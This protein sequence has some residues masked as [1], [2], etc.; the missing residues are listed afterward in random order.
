VIAFGL[1]LLIPQR[2]QLRT[3]GKEVA[4]EMT[5]QFARSLTVLRLLP[6]S[7]RLRRSH[8]QSSVGAERIQETIR[9][10][11]CHIATVPLLRIEV[12]IVREQSNPAHGKRLYPRR[13]IPAREFERP[14]ECRRVGY[15]RSLERSWSETCRGGIRL[16]DVPGKQR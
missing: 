10:Q 5:T 15:E 14:I 6:T 16:L 2:R 4:T 7:E 3:G 12:H 9:L 1:G 11:S 13:N 8:R